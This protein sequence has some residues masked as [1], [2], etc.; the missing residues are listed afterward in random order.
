LI[1]SA[2]ETVAAPAEAPEASGFGAGSAGVAGD[3][4]RA[5]VEDSAVADATTV[6]VTLVTAIR[7]SVAGARGSRS[8]AI[9]K[10]IIRGEPLRF[11]VIE[12]K[13]GTVGARF[14]IFS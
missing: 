4:L 11:C 9:A 8:A 5:G 1:A 3:G 7:E 2:R 10:I 12:C 13:E 14:S 6:V